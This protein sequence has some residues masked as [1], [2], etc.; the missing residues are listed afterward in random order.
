M[1]SA[2]IGGLAGALGGGLITYFI[3]SVTERRKTREKRLD[4]LLKFR[5][6]AEDLCYKAGDLKRILKSQQEE[7]DLNGARQTLE[8]IRKL[9][10]IDMYEIK[11]TFHHY[12]LFIDSETL[13]NT[14]DFL[15]ATGHQVTTE[16]DYFSEM[17][18]VVTEPQTRVTIYINGRIKNL[19]LI[20]S[21]ADKL[22]QFIVN[23]SHQYYAEYQ[24]KYI[25]KSNSK[26]PI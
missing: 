11:N 23:K 4:I 13:D 10:V 22:Y 16:E 1:S 24:K 21:E 18:Q 2:I 14:V 20:A 6:E 26:L 25:N 19:E 8:E 7:N 3:Y 5:T 12:A 9:L 17:K 15:N